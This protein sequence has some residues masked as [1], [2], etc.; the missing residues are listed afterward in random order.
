MWVPHPVET[1]YAGYA[2]ELDLS[3]SSLPPLSVSD[4]GGDFSHV[5]L[6]Y[7]PRTGS[8][9][10][11]EAIAHRY[12]GAT[13]ANVLVTT[14]AVEALWLVQTTFLRSGDRLAVRRP[15][16]PALYRVAT[17]RGCSL[18]KPGEPAALT[19]LNSPHNP[20]GA[21]TT[22]R[23]MAGVAAKSAV[24]AVDEVF[25]GVSCLPEP[26]TAFSQG[27]ISIGSA[28]KTLAMPGARIG[29]LVGPEAII[30]ELSER[31]DDTTLCPGAL[32]EAVVI[33]ALQRFDEIADRHR[34]HA[35]ANWERVQA[36]F[37][38]LEVAVARPEGGVTIW[39]PL[40][41]RHSLVFC[42]RLLAETGVGLLPG[43][44]LG[45]EGHA[46]LGFGADRATLAE[47]LK[48]LAPFWRWYTARQ[49][50][51]GDRHANFD[52]GTGL[53][54]IGD[55]GDEPLVPGPRRGQSGPGLS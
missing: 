29:W 13:P 9:E 44:L 16:Y 35:F 19:L 23:E 38:D 43:V 18:V 21:L 15:C 2:A 49:S 32:G 10:L 17:A 4:V 34:D 5:V 48:R 41:T 46:R 51:E 12:P 6:G 26:P 3:T 52:T 27:G 31:R 39:L 50:L 47:G 24:W 22:V 45:E 30:S 28:S 33:E 42:E 7:R 14:G 25:R 8:T 11:R 1:W 20:T 40:P 37:D 53:H 36:C 55:S 54:R